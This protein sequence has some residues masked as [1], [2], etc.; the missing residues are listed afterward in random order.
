MCMQVLSASIT[1][2]DATDNMYNVKFYAGLITVF[3]P[4][5][6]LSSLFM[7]LLVFNT[8][9]I[10]GNE[11]ATQTVRNEELGSKNAYFISSSDYVT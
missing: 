8:Q 4:R 10:S 11:K 1:D 9:Q 6:V 3:D 5:L 7:W 2:M